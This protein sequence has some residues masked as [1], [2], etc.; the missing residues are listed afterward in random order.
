MLISTLLYSSIK[1][2]FATLS[3]VS[4]I[5]MQR[6]YINVMFQLPNKVIDCLPRV[7][8]EETIG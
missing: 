2:S 3:V 1:I 6:V 5:D 8:C 7:L 4:H